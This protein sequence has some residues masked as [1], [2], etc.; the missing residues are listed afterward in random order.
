MKYY[1]F[2]ILQNQIRPLLWFSPGNQLSPTQ[3]LALS[4]LA[5]WGR[6]LEWQK[7]ENFAWDKDSLI[8]KSKAVPVSKI[9][10]GVDLRLSIGRKVFSYF[11]ESR[12][13]SHMLI[14]EEY[15]CHNSKCPSASS[16]FPKLFCWAWRYMVWDIALVSFP[17]CAP[18][19]LPI[20]NI[21]TSG[22]RVRNRE[23]LDAITYGTTKYKK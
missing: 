16:F 23:S 2:F 22:S 9:K 4:P 7:W 13:P 5:R 1:L 21:L 14:T 11:Q 15:K 10:W 3:A 17:G 18:S 6:E 8:V 12:T 19:H 20:P